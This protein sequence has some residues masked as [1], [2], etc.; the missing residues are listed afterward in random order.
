[1]GH[2]DVAPAVEHEAPAPDGGRGTAPSRWR[3]ARGMVVSR[4]LTLLAISLVTFVAT[5][6]L[7]IDV[8]RQALGRGITDEQAAAFVQQ[9]GLDAP[10]PQRYLGWLGDFVTG[11]WGT[12]PLTGRSVWGEI[13]PRLVNPLLL[14]VGCLVV[15]LPVSL[16]L[17]ISMARRAGQRRETVFLAGTV[18]VAAIP[19]FV[20]GLLLILVFAVRLGIAPADST[21]LAFGTGWTKARAFILP[22]LTLV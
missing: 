10:L 7:G 13:A 5:N 15:A 19:W 8:A 1:M 22:V 16:L 2:P 4:L 6:A 9:Y 21:G 11:D 12:S 20:V 18:V 17:G 14:A 3:V